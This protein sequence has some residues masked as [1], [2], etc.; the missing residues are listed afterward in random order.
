MTEKLVKGLT[1]Q[2]Y[3][4]KRYLANKELI[5]EKGREYR[6]LNEKAVKEYAHNYNRRNKEYNQTRQRY[7]NYGLTAEA[8]NKLMGEQNG[9]CANPACRMTNDGKALCVDHV[10]VVD[11]EDL[12]PEEKAKLVRGLLCS[13]CNAGIG[14]FKE[15]SDLFIGAMSYLSKTLRGQV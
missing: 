1:P 7:Y 12:P 11:Y 6:K 5:K 8:W 4:R 10:H 13:Y 9:L 3:R 15:N 14:Y 2:E